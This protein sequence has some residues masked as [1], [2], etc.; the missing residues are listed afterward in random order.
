LG[1]GACGGSKRSLR[2]SWGAQ[3]SPST[4]SDLH[5]KIYAKMETLRSQPITDSFAYVYLDG[6]WL[7]PEQK[8]EKFWILSRA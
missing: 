8:C 7:K 1:R 4:V 6:I 3:V 2:L 5:Q